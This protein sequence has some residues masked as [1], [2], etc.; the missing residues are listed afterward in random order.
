MT[1]ALQAPHPCATDAKKV[2][3]ASAAW[4]S[5]HLHYSRVTDRTMEAAHPEIVRFS[6]A[7]DARRPGALRGGENGRRL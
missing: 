7:A 3:L 6:R 2:F 4:C 5:A 1:T